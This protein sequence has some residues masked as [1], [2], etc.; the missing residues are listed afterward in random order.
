[1][2]FVWVHAAAESFLR[3]TSV[4]SPFHSVV[5]TRTTCAGWRPPPGGEVILVVYI[6]DNALA[7]CTFSVDVQ[8]A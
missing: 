8:N 2:G 7:M 6:V 1:M 4:A 5:T 3:S